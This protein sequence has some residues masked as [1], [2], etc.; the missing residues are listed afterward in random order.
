M[1]F[2]AAGLLFLSI[3]GILLA[4]FYFK[5]Y[6][7]FESEEQT[8]NQPPQKGLLN[9]FYFKFYKRFK[10]AINDSDRFK[11][12]MINDTETNFI[13]YKFSIAIV[14]L[15]FFLVVTKSPIVSLISFVVGWF[16]PTLI[17]SSQYKD[18]V[19]SIAVELPKL[20]RYIRMYTS[21][22]YNMDNSLRRVDEYLESPLK[23]LLADAM[24]EIKRDADPH[25]HLMAV[26]NKIRGGQYEAKV[27]AVFKRIIGGWANP[28]AD[29]FKD[30]EDFL[31]ELERAGI[32]KNTNAKKLKFIMLLPVAFFSLVIM[33]A[34]VAIMWIFNTM[35]TL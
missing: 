33:V 18:W 17:I 6:T 25:K 24:I 28:N 31:L 29:S 19:D 30:M 34:P 10:W 2:I 8:N 11:L 35:L 15:L 23:P 21:M 12:Q 32:E 4:Q 26:R 20:T 22:G 9:R 3:L 1:E 13:R 16:I 14:C 7:V 27:D 5:D